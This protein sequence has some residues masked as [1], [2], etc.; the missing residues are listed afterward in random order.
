MEEKQKKNKLDDEWLFNLDVK[1]I[2][3][4]EI[5]H[6]RQMES[7]P[8]FSLLQCQSGEDR[9]QQQSLLLVQKLSSF[10]NPSVFETAENKQSFGFQSW[11]TRECPVVWLSYM[12]Q[13]VESLLVR[14]SA[15]KIHAKNTTHSLQRVKKQTHKHTHTRLVLSSIVLYGYFLIITSTPERIILKKIHHR[16]YSVSFL[17]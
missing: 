2:K 1:L 13:Q 6:Y 11:R 4:P 3:L 10:Y 15:I 7:F 12:Q 14:P 9:Y 17:V 8:T 5:Q 16:L